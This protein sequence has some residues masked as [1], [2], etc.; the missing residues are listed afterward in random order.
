MLRTLHT[1]EEQTQDDRIK[2]AAAGI[3]PTSRPAA[4]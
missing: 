1:L 4:R 2:E 3:A